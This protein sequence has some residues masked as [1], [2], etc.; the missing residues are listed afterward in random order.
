MWSLA[1]IAF[2]IRLTNR[3]QNLRSSSGREIEVKLEALTKA[4]GG[5]V[6]SNADDHIDD[7][8]TSIPK[9]MFTH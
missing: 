3:A 8:H 1:L 5:A 6:Y 4:G 9:S 2:P 7:L